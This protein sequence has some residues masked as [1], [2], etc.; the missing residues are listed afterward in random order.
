MEVLTE[1]PEFCHWRMMFLPSCYGK[2]EK[3]GE[4]I[5][6]GLFQFT[7]VYATFS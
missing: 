1:K 2:K 3:H 6:D 5:G 4:T 7:L